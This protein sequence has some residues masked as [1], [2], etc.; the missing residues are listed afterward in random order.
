MLESDARGEETSPGM[1]EEVD[2]STGKAASEVGHDLEDVGHVVRNRQRG[3]GH[4]R[5]SEDTALMEVADYRIL[6]EGG[7]HVRAKRDQTDRVARPAMQVEEYGTRLSRAADL[8]EQRGA[9]ALDRH[10]VVD[11]R[12][13]QGRWR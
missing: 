2:R 5:R 4:R 9:R 12:C 6:L 10:R 3:V 11:G 1:A 7:S 8:E 13:L